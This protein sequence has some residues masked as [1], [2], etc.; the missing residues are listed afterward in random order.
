MSFGDVGDVVDDDVTESFSVVGES[1]L[2]VSHFK[3]SPLGPVNFG[4]L[5]S[6]YNK[7]NDQVNVHIVVQNSTDKTKI[8][9]LFP[10]KFPS[11]I[12]PKEVIF[13]KSHISK[14]G[15]ISRKGHI[16]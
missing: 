11:V 10:Q 15:H 9:L 16:S 7:K 12:F 4:M 6:F 13:P 14:K 8:D 3:S 5:F 2:S 1:D